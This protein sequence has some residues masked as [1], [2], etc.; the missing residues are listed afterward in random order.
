VERRAVSARP[1]NPIVFHHHVSGLY[2]RPH[3]N[4]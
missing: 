2:F 1:P 3:G 4:G